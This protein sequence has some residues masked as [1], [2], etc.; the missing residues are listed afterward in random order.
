MKKTFLALIFTALLLLQAFALAEAGAGPEAYLGQPMPDFT[1]TTISGERF[2]LS[3]AVSRNKAVLVNL[4]ATWCGPCEMEFPYM[5]EAYERYQDEVEIIALSIEPTDSADVLTQYAEAHGMT[6]Q[7]AN[8]AEAGMGGIFVTSGIPTT[9]LVDRFG[10]V[11]LIEVGAQ[12]TVDP[13]ANAF[14][15]LISDSYTETTVMDGFPK[16]KPPVSAGAEGQLAKAV[17][18]PFYVAAS[19]DEYAWPFAASEKDGKRCIASTNAGV[20]TSAA[21]VLVCASAQPGDAFA[22]SFRLSSEARY[23][24]F[25]IKLNGALVNAFSGEVDWTAFAVPLEEGEN[26]VSLSYNKDQVEDGGEDTLYLAD[27]AL[28]SGEA[29][30]AAIAESAAVGYPYA[31]ETSVSVLNEDAREIVFCDA[32]GNPVDL[33]YLFGTENASYYI[34][35]GGT[36]RFAASLS[37]VMESDDMMLVGNTATWMADDILDAELSDTVCAEGAEYGNIILMNASSQ[38]LHTVVFL[39][40]SEDSASYFETLLAQN[41]ADCAYRYADGSERSA[42]GAADT[43][44]AAYTVT[45]I[46]QNGDPVP[47]C[48]INFCTDETCVP[49]VANEEGV[50]TFEG[51]PYP[52]HL[53][54]IRVPNGY[55]FDTAQEFTAEPNGGELAFVVTKK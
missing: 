30:A 1:V 17:N 18:M 4:W 55:E 27:F 32:A 6:F 33:N 26:V 21:E 41:G 15:A 14:E 37:R 13:F 24:R 42:G 16:R 46:D 9:I 7:V 29:A 52:Y 43:G 31:E 20:G 47:G 44:L 53:Q 8:D 45:F 36:V 23:D 25:S 22:F 38:A 35:P 5:E 12:T 40:P 48:I 2:T 54:V 10:N 39:F 50:A 3:E 51:E 49:T 19:Q 11:V 34:V 28:L